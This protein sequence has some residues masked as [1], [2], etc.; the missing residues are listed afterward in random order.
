M[1][2]INWSLVTNVIVG[3]LQ[4]NNFSWQDSPLWFAAY[5]MQNSSIFH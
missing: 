5:K 2:E 3:Q 1:D 4:N